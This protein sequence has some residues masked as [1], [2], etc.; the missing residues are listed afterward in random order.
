MKYTREDVISDP[1][2]AQE[3]ALGRCVFFGDGFLDAL[4]KAN[5][6][7]YEFFGGLERI[8]LKDS[9][10]F[11]VSQRGQLIHEQFIV[12]MKEDL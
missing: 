1:Y 6:E 2:V 9:F 11:Y 12:V 3:R 4:D 10:P 7:D 8:N 5:S